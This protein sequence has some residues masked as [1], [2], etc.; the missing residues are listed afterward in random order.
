MTHLPTV[1]PLANLTRLGYSL[2]KPPSPVA[3]YVPSVR[4][5]NLLFVAGQ[6]PLRDGVLLATGSVPT[7]VS[8]ER[9][10]ECAVQC[11]LN[12]LAIAQAATGDLARIG[13]VV[14]LGVFVACD[15]SFVDHPK[16]ANGASELLVE[17]F[18]ERG[19]HARA[20]VGA[21]SLPLG[22]PVEIEFT[23]ELA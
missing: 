2:P 7:A 5:G 13:R 12:G 4:S 18:G 20:A 22:A 21:P 8:L 19:K 15:A 9:A 11:A 14:R 1:D 16:V 10:R 23:F 3:A 6:I 17:V